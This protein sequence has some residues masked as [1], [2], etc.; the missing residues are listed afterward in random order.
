[1]GL[2]IS[3]TKSE[4]YGKTKQEALVSLRSKLRYLYDPNIDIYKSNR[5]GN[6]VYNVYNHKCYIIFEKHNNIIRAYVVQ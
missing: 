4:G 3:Q 5:N 1:M 2:S 6:Y